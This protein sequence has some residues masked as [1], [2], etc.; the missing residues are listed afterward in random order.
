MQ[1]GEW[2]GMDRVQK[3]EPEECALAAAGAREVAKAALQ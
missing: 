3:L 1:A 2:D